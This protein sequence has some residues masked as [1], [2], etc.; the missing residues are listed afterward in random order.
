MKIICTWLVTAFTEAPV[1]PDGQ[2][3]KVL[4]QPEFDQ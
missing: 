2:H 4:L 1:K 3:L